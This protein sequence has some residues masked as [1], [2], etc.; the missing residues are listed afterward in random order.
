MTTQD[1]IK[2]LEE[3]MARLRSE[4]DGLREQL[5]QAEVDRWQERVDDLELQVHLATMETNEKVNQLFQ[6]VQHRWAA[7]KAQLERRSSAAT[8]GAE[9]VRESLRTAFAEIRHAILETT[10]KIAS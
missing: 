10:H 8:E 2:A 4:Q 5:A 3:Q 7:G 1:R 9:A 6:Q